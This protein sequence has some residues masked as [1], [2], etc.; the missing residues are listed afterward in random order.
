MYSTCLFCSADLGA[1]EMIEEF[2]VGGSLAFDAERGRLWAVCPKCRRWNL[3]PI[4]ER[5]E[6][7]ESSEKLF[8][9]SRLRVH[10]ENIGLCK[11]PDGTR[12]IRV[13]DAV[14]REFA[15]WR[16]GDELVRRRKQ[17]LLLGWN[18]SCRGRRWQAQ[19]RSRWRGSLPRLPPFMCS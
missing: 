17:A 15:A 9:S 5:W 1:N 8:R 11:L 4:E 2:P 19:A 16:Y 14:P 7:V 10:S 13:G 6:A 3:A 12:L 18:R